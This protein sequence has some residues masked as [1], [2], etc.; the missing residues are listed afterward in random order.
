MA[1]LEVSNVSVSFGGVQALSEVSMCAEPGQITGLIGPNGAGKSTLLAVQSGFIRPSTGHVRLSGTD[2]T[3][4]SPH[5]R[6]KLG[7]ARTFQRLEL[8]TSLT[9]RDNI[10]TA[11]EFASRWKPGLKPRAVAAQ[12]IEQLALS[13]VAATPAGQLPSGI[14]RLTE[15]AR[16]LA[17]SPSVLLLDEPSAGLDESESDELTKVLIDVAAAGTA[18]VLVEHHLDMVMT[19]CEHIWVLDFGKLIAHG[20][21]RKIRA[22]EAVQNS[23]LGSS[24]AT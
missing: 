17:S 18:I 2:I 21:A 15:V 14:A 16:A 9:V 4:L 8:W 1:I 13:A 3:T 22:S 24:H 5:V 12:L 19:V 20:N 23:Y 11:A 7:M 10:V 6:A